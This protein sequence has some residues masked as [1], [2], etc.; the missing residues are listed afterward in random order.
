M[1]KRVVFQW[2]IRI[3]IV[4]IVI[5]VAVVHVIERFAERMICNGVRA[6]AGWIVTLRHRDSLGAR[7]G[8]G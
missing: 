8:A 5:G 3:E 2:Q 1:P 4:V 7:L 6:F